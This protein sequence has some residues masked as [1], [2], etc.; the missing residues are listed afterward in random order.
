[1]INEELRT[2]IYVARKDY[3]VKQYELAEK[4]GIPDYKLTRVLQSELTIPQQKKIAQA[5]QELVEE[6]AIMP[7]EFVKL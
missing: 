1:M 4:L 5:L 6:K 7:L 3:G 2:S